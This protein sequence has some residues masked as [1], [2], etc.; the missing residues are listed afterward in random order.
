ME[1][2]QVTGVGRFD[3]GSG[4]RQ[5]RVLPTELVQLM[6]MLVGVG[7]GLGVAEAGQEFGPAR[8]QLAPFCNVVTLGVEQQGAAY[9]LTGWDDNCSGPHSAAFGTV[10]LK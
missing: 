5:E 6:G 4:S 1:E 7:L 3:E 8:W 2:G 10:L 9:G